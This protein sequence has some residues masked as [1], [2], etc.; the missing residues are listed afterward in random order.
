MRICIN[1]RDLTDFQRN[2]IERYFEDHFSFEGKC[3]R[4]VW[5]E[6]DSDYIL[7][8]FPQGDRTEPEVKA[9]PQDAHSAPV[10]MFRVHESALLEIAGRGQCVDFPTPG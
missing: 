5:K 3:P 1:S 10:V 7:L 4:L 2:R 6:D 8:G 9:F